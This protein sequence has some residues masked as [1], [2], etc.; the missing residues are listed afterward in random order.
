MDEDEGQFDF[1]THKQAAVAA[2]L[3]KRFFF[4]EHASVIKRIVEEALLRRGIKVSSVEAREK[5][6]ESFGR[7]AAQPSDSN[8]TKPKYDSPMQQITDLTGVRIITFFPNTLELVG[9]LLAEEFDVIEKTDKTAML[10]AEERFGYSSVHYLVRLNK[11]R[12]AL[13][14]YQKFKG[15]TA[16]VQVRTVLQHAWAEIEHDI[17]YKSASVI[18]ASIRRRFTALAGMLELAD[19]EFQAVQDED[20]RIRQT[21]RAQI[22]EGELS[23]VEI[24]P[25]A[26]KQFLDKTI[27]RD[28]RISSVSYDFAARELRALGFS[29]LDQVRE[30]IAG[31]DDDK[32]SRIV[33]GNRQGQLYR[34]FLVVAAGI[35]QLYAVRHPWSKHGWF[36]VRTAKTFEELESA[37]IK[38]G[39]YDPLL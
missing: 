12:L 35:G 23:D 31:Y 18:P 29:T 20:D 28:D 21:A 32:I 34:F 9:E 1:N 4:K 27:G 13:P 36:Q 2:Y 16:E 3:E 6:P 26:L 39:S 11:S 30:C 17:Q 14:E 37:G 33:Y 15:T 22:D 38:I 19:R 8:P 5:D 10:H 24:T 25:D 7:K